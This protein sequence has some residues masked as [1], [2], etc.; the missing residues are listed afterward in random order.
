MLFG[1]LT[2]RT[3]RTSAP[4]RSNSLEPFKYWNGTSFIR[5]NERT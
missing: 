2:E 1:R 4:R 5:F 3:T